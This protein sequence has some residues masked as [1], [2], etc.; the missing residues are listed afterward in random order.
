VPNSIAVGPTG[1]LWLAGSFGGTLLTDPD[2]E[3]PLD[4]G[5]GP[6]T[7]ESSDD[8]FLAKFDASGALE[9]LEPHLGPTLV[10]DGAGNAI[11]THGE[12]DSFS[13]VKV[14]P[15]DHQLARIEIATQLTGP[16]SFSLS[17]L[18]IEGSRVITAAGSVRG[19]VNLIGTGL[20]VSPPDAGM[21]FIARLDMSGAPLFVRTLGPPPGTTIFKDSTVDSI[22]VDQA[23]H[24]LVTGFG[25][26]E[27]ALLGETLTATSSEFVL[28]LDESGNAVWSKQYSVIAPPEA[29]FFGGAVLILATMPFQLG[30]YDLTGAGPK[31]F[32][33]LPPDTDPNAG[34]GYLIPSSD[35]RVWIITPSTYAECP[36][37]CFGSYYAEAFDASGKRSANAVLYS[38][39]GSVG[40]ERIAS[41]SDRLAVVGYLVG[42]IDTHT[43]DGT[44]QY[45][46]PAHG[47]VF[48]I[49]DLFEDLQR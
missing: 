38:S 15:D 7:A 28:M 13:L 49:S 16:N 23:G 40:I 47:E 46:P 21:G 4:L 48:I 35:G 36:E 33:E 5:H 43:V 27:I 42:E 1:Q 14:S 22:D 29:T 39:R 25:D 8:T 2:T 45:A 6:I 17:D 11:V 19:A 20:V 3:R 26:G 44:F 31:P 30:S 32:A 34:Q 41:G 12:S 24:V 10:L 18:A 9:W 37:P